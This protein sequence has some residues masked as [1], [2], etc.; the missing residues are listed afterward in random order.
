MNREVVGRPMEILLVEDNRA[1][2]RLAIEAL[3]D[4][5]VKHRLTLVWDGYEA[6]EF[7]HQQGP[8]TQAP[9]PDLILLD[10]ELPRK[11]GRE[12]L[13][14]IK[15][16]YELKNIPVVILTASEAHED[17]LRSELLHVEGYMTKPVDLEKFIA[18]VKRLKKYWHE[19]VI[20]P[21]AK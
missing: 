1:D 18:L 8:F 13:A 20:L 21:E 19:D 10:L 16:D 2:A 7:L 9:H 12:V 17:I 4:G 11:D 15:A 6:M 3:K 14:E 5:R